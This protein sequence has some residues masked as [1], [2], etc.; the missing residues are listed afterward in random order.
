MKKADQKRRVG[1]PTEHALDRDRKPYREKR[2]G[3]REGIE[4]VACDEKKKMWKYREERRTHREKRRAREMKTIL[5]ETRSQREM[6][7]R[8]ETR[9]PVWEHGERVT[10][11]VQR[12]EA[13]SIVHNCWTQGLGSRASHVGGP[14][15]NFGCFKNT[16]FGSWRPKHAHK[17][18]ISSHTNL[19]YV[20]IFLKAELIRI[21]FYINPKLRLNSYY[22]KKKKVMM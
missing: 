8:R 17:I 14:N 7:K 3:W 4:E 19:F 9:G 1:E 5:R 21:T 22:D 13:T 12:H 16:G 11:T 6:K 10:S 2:I 20:T 15:A 18:Y